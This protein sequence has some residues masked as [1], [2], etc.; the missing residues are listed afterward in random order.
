M[1]VG[2]LKKLSKNLNANDNVD[3]E[4]APS[5]AQADEILAKFGYVEEE[6]LQLAA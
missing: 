1:I 4:C 2:L 3:M 6:A 5:V